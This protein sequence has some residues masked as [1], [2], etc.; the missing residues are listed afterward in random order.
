MPI[1]LCTSLG[2]TLGMLE[3]ANIRHALQNSLDGH[4]GLDMLGA[5]FEVEKNAKPDDGVPDQEGSK[6]TLWSELLKHASALSFTKSILN[7]DA[8]LI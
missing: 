7:S 3:L 2:A 8:I 5:E 6:Q 4:A 1:C